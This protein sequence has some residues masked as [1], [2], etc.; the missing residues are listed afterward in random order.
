MSLSSPADFDFL[1]GSWNVSHRR[2]NERLAN[3]DEWT[4]FRGTSVAQ[5]VLG[6][7]G[8]I[9]D[10]LLDLPGAPYR[11]VTLR[12]FD[13]EKRQW[14]IWWLDGRNPGTLDLPV[15]GR[16]ANG[17][18]VFYGDDVFN[19]RRIRVRYIWTVPKPDAP[20]WEQAF[21]VDAGATWETNWTMDFVRRAE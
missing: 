8:N 16:F 12:S 4:E 3:C 10:N 18:G 2:L 1:M 9:D 5:K 13:A 20:H 6:G 15:V 21:S 7:L 14:T 19:G 11:A 17:V